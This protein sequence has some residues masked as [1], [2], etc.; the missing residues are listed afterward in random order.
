METYEIRQLLAARHRERGLTQA[1][2]GALAQVRREMILRF[3]K[4]DHD[5]GLSK[6]AQSAGRF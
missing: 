1:Q 4:G 5:I 6:V 2:P 3:G